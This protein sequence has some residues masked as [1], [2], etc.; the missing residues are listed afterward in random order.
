[1]IFYCL[2]Q[3]KNI[4]NKREE[5]DG[6]N[7]LNLMR[8]TPPKISLKFQCKSTTDITPVRVK[9]GRLGVKVIGEVIKDGLQIVLL[10]SL[11]GI[12]KA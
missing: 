5:S 9:E 10:G 2:Y 3:P 11:A 4:L 8:S 6:A 1:M 7:T 12:K